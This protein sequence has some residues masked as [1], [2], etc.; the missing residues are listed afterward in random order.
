MPGVFG[1][2]RQVKRDSRFAGTA[3]L[4]SHNDSFHEKDNNGILFFM[5]DGKCVARRRATETVRT[6]SRF[7]MIRVFG[8]LSVHVRAQDGV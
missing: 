6:P 3:F 1:G 5:K 8:F 4:V 7:R 2:G